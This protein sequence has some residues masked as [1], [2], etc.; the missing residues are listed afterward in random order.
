[1][2]D[3]PSALH[4]L[5]VVNL[6]RSCSPSTQDAEKV[7]VNARRALRRAVNDLT[8]LLAATSTF[9]RTVKWRTGCEGRIS[10][11]KRGDGWDRTRIDGTQ[12]ARTW[13]GHRVLAPNLV[14]IAALT[15]KPRIKDQQ[16]RRTPPVADRGL[17]QVQVS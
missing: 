12:G 6:H 9:R 13:T 2:V 16:L 17:F 14:K 8:E 15:A 5:T 4:A 7:L 1:V 3:Q 10:T 11:L